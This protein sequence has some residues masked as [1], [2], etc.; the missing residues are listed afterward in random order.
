MLKYFHLVLFSTLL[1]WTQSHCQSETL[2][3]LPKEEALQRILEGEKKAFIFAPYRNASGAKLTTAEKSLLNEGKMT[4]R[5]F[6]DAFGRIKQ[7][8]CVPISSDEDLFYEI[9]LTELLA[10]NPLDKIEQIEINCEPNNLEKLY[11]ELQMKDQGYRNGSYESP[12]GNPD[13]D[14]RIILVSIIEQCG[15][16]STEA[17]VESA[18]FVIQHSGHSGLMEYYHH[19]FKA[20]VESELLSKTKMA[21]MDDRLLM[22]HGFSQI[23]GTQLSGGFRSPDGTEN[24]LGQTFGFHD[25]RDWSTV[26]ERRAEVGLEPIEVYAKRKGIVLFGEEQEP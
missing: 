3:E 22:T 18:W 9:R 17:G 25:I 7:V 1:C 19:R 21:T 11:A 15:F 8:Q 5:Y 16:P 6:Q 24:T 2:V 26:N 13:V 10:T 23:Y 12:D 20:A 14:N 4:R